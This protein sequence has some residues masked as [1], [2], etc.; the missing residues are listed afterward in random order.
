MPVSSQA[1]NTSL[2]DLYGPYVP[3]YA[4][5]GFKLQLHH[6]EIQQLVVMAAN[7]RQA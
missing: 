7:N 3:R 4:S 6:L 2:D 5:H 1:G